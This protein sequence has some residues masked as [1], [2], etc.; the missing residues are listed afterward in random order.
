[1]TNS[2]LRDSLRLEMPVFGS[3]MDLVCT[4]SRDQRHTNLC[5]SLHQRAFYSAPAHGAG[6]LQATAD[7]NRAFK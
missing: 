5:M 1:M 2:A 3:I 4:A 7:T 6:G